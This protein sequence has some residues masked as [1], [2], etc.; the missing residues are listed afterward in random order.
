MNRRQV[1]CGFVAAVVVACLGLAASATAQTTWYVEKYATGDAPVRVEHLWARGP[2]FRSEA[3]IAGHPITTIVKG[4]RY[5]II[6]ELNRTGVAIQRAPEAIRDEKTVPRPFGNELMGLQQA[7]GEFVGVET[8]GTNECDMYRL[9]NQEGRREVCATR[10]DAKLPILLRAWMRRSQRQIE[11]RY[12]NWT[13]RL[14]IPETYFEPDPRIPLTQ[15][16][17]QEY[18][19]RVA[20]DL[21]LP[22]PPLY[23]DLLHGRGDS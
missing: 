22:A 6:D 17:Y 8:F 14:Q 4:D 3:V 16:P 13:D 7:G 2:M 23:R 18:V 11:A 12:V 1:S 9:T 19:D 21:E 10:D 20:K 15:I 5:I